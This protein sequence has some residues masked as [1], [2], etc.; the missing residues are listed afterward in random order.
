MK[1][2]RNRR[3]AIAAVSAVV[4]VAVVGFAGL[5]IDLTRIWMVN[6]RLKTAIDA[7]SLVAARQISLPQ[8]ERD[9]Q[10]QAV[11]WANFSQNGTSY[12]Y[13]GATVSN[14]VI[15]PLIDDPLFPPSRIQVSGTATVPTTLFSIISRNNTVVSDSAIAVRQGTGLEVSLVLDVTGSMGVTNIAALRTAATDLLDILYAGQERQPNLWVSVVPYTSVVNI[16]ANRE[17]WLQPGSLNQADFAPTVWRGCVEARVGANYGGGAFDE[18]ETPP[19]VVPFRPHFVPSNRYTYSRDPNDANNV[20]VYRGGRTGPL[21]S[22]PL[23]T[24]PAADWP[25]NRGDNA[26]IPGPGGTVIA[27]ATA[28]WTDA[29]WEPNPNAPSLGQDGLPGDALD[30]A[31]GNEARGPNLGCGRA[32]LPLTRD[33]TPVQAQID[34]LRHTHRGGTMANLGLQLGWGTLSPLWRADWGL[35]EQRE[36]QTLPLDYGTRAMTKAIVLMTDGE[37]LWHDWAN[38]LPGNN[39]RTLDRNNATAVQDCSEINLAVLPEGPWTVT[40]S[41]GNVGRPPQP[42]YRAIGNNDADQTGYGRLN[43]RRLGAGITNNGQALPEINRRMTNLC[44]AIKARGIT[45][46][47]V[48]FVANPSQAITDLYRGCASAPENYFPAP[49]RE[50]LNAAFRTIAGQLANLRLA[51]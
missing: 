20:L 44:T 24:V 45:V 26:W 32:V 40:S 51:Q 16:G 11:Y 31:R 38:G 23:A 48:V 29:V 4:M 13:L 19:S 9:A 7:A 28:A 35:T 34:A 2:L 25:I 47:T 37:N 14:A 15:T 22:V 43:E 50:T 1:I 39:C 12:N 46:Y 5:A 30:A 18:T 3:G 36:G 10:V 41:G 17:N 8:A 21:V 27:E 33:R 49:T 6:A 42:R